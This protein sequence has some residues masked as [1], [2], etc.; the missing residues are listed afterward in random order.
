MPMFELTCPQGALD[1]AARS[2][3]ADDLSTALLRAEGAPDTEFFRSITWGYVRE[4]PADAVLAGGRPVA[5]PTFRL[6]VTTP[7]GALSDR[8]R[9]GLMAEATRVVSEAAGLSEGEAGRVWVLLHEIPDG[10]W[11][12]A[13]RVVRYQQL[14]QFARGEAK[15]R[16]Q[17]G[18]A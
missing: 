15:K 13:G 17:V 6:D 14:V 2:R 5:A 7:E 10:S 16:E 3:L 11:G 18:T 1:P 8:R 9:E 4:L 12:A